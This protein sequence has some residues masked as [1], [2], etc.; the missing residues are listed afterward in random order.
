MAIKVLPVEHDDFNTMRHFVQ[1]RDGQL[2]DVT[3]DHAMPVQTDEQAAIRNDWYAD[4]PFT[5]YQRYQ[6]DLNFDTTS[7]S[8]QVQQD[9]FSNDRTVHFI[10]A[11]DTENGDILAMAHW[12]F[13]PHGYV[14][15]ALDFAGLK[16]P[17][18]PASYP[19]GLNVGLYKAI[20]SGMIDQRPLWTGDGPQRSMRR[21]P[22]YRLLALKAHKKTDALH[23]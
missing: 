1:S 3:S 9:I 15:S 4:T 16:D 20:L 14:P 6:R 10:K 18:A 19:E 8:L 22:V 11:V 7:T 2:S 17:D 12:R 23:S 21:S 13:Y 5:R